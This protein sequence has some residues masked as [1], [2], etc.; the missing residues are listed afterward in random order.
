[1]IEAH[2]APEVCY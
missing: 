1:M 2:T